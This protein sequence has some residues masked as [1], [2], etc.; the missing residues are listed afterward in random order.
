MEKIFIRLR[1]LFFNKEITIVDNDRTYIFRTAHKK[2]FKY[3]LEEIHDRNIALVRNASL[4][5]IR[6]DISINDETWQM[7]RRLG[8]SEILF[9]NGSDFVSFSEE[10]KTLLSGSQK[11]LEWSYKKP[12]LKKAPELEVMLY[13]REH[14]TLLLP[15][16]A[17]LAYDSD[18]G[19]D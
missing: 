17:V 1:Y 9:S 6:W 5:K 10:Q 18:A 12:F 13:S 19:E 3:M 2:L 7:T 11:V 16:M 4:L 15:Y 14:Y 8:S